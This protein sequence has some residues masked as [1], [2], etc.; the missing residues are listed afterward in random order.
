MCV[1]AVMKK[2]LAGI[3]I[4]AFLCGSSACNNHTEKLSETETTASSEVT[5]S[6]TEV[7]E[8][9]PS[10][11]SETEPDITDASESSDAAVMPSWQPEP[12]ETIELDRSMEILDIATPDVGN[13][14]GALDPT[15][16][17]VMYIATGSTRLEIQNEGYEELKKELG[18]IFDEEESFFENL[19]NESIPV[20]LSEIAEGKS[21]MWVTGGND[22]RVF[23]ADEKIVS[24]SENI[25]W[26]KE[27]SEDQY[28][29]DNSTIYYT[30][31]SKTGKRVTL[32]DVVADKEGLCDCIRH[33][34]QYSMSKWYGDETEWVESVCT[35]VMDGS[36]Q[37]YLLYDGIML[38]EECRF[39][40]L[41]AANYPGVFSME[42]FFSVPENYVL[43]SDSSGV[44]TWDLNSDGKTE[45]IFLSEY[46]DSAGNRSAAINIGGV[47][48]K[49]E[50]DFSYDVPDPDYNFYLAH[51]SEG[52]FLL[53]GGSCGSDD[54]CEIIFRIKDDFSAEFVETGVRYSTQEYDPT[55]MEFMSIDDAYSAGYFLERESYSSFTLTGERMVNS[56]EE[57]HGLS[58]SVMVTKMDIKCKIR[59]DADTWKEYTLPKGTVVR[60]I[61]YSPAAQELILEILHPDNKDNQQIRISYD[62]HTFDGVDPFELFEGITVGG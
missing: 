33:V 6:E 36:V 17:R 48:T 58:G 62:T 34:F 51:T 12:A 39:I 32:D 38:E 42:Y 61:S 46:T 35:H 1:E 5:V 7:S 22:I 29:G 26:T 56:K 45:K 9:E 52:F 11:T 60:A 24:F 37:F 25:A 50:N 59:E 23:R 19:Y 21:L 47:E 4:V 3:L 54:R 27:L 30:F 57:Q 14:Y 55:K 41:S 43:L 49:I 44:M 18:K 28:E 10:E 31:H 40:H 53:A 8:S 20:F 2:T 15:T 16:G 13:A